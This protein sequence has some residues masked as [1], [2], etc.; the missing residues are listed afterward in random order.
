LKK[1]FSDGRAKAGGYGLYLFTSVWFLF[2]F[3]FFSVSSTKLPNYIFPAIPAASVMCGVYCSELLENRGGRRSAFY[4]MSALS[5]ILSAAFYITPFTGVKMEIPFSI[6]FFHILGGIFLVAALFSFKAALRPA[7]YIGGIA[8]MTAVLL[9][10]LRL[11]A[12]PPVNIFFQKDL[13]T[14]ATYARGLSDRALLAT[15]EIN[16]PSIAFYS[17]GRVIKFERNNIKDIP[18][19]STGKSLLIITTEKNYSELSAAN[20]KV[21]DRR[22]PYVLMSDTT[23]LP[24][25]KD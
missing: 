2:I 4:A 24:P 3:L 14:Y 11:Y 15:Y 1:G 20:L 23:E 19:H 9:I 7:R 5:L 12:V 8:S 16:R 6:R 18:R 21:I 25:L 10:F 13:Y 17:A 22:G